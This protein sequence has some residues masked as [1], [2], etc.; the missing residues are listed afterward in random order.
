MNLIS[1]YDYSLV[2]YEIY[3]LDLEKNFADK[4]T[5]KVMKS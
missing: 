4:Y 2:A 1:E 3:L 5:W